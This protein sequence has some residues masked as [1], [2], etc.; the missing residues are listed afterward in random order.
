MNKFDL[1]ICEVLFNK[2]YETI[3]RDL[4]IVFGLQKGINSLKSLLI[5]KIEL[6]QFV[7]DFHFKYVFLFVVED[8]SVVLFGQ[9]NIADI[10]AGLP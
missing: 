6:F 8:A 2:V 9:F 5:E 4:S 10:V 1:I 3:S 7:I